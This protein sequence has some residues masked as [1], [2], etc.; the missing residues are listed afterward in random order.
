MQDAGKLNYELSAICPNVKPL[1]EKD[2]PH[3][4]DFLYKNASDGENYGS[5]N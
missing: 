2:I 3:V 4:Y 1:K 5:K